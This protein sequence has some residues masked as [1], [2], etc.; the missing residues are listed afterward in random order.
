[1]I[2]VHVAHKDIKGNIQSVKEHSETTA[3]LASEYS[4]MKFKGLVY[5][6]ALFHDI[7][8]YQA[9]FQKRIAGNKNIKIPHALCGAIELNHVMKRSVER[10]IMQY[11]IA[12]HHTGLHNFGTKADT[13]GQGTL[14]GTLQLETEDYSEYKKEIS[15]TD[16]EDISL[17]FSEKCKTPQE[18]GECF[19]FVTRYVYS[20][21]TDADSI[22]TETFCNGYERNRRNSDFQRCL[23]KINDRLNSFVVET[24]LQKA[25]SK[26]QSQ[27]YQKLLHDGQIFFINMP[28][29][30]GKTLCSMKFA[31]E[32]AIQFKKK[33]IIYIIPYNSVIDQTATEF[34]RVFGADLNILRHQSSFKYEVEDGVEEDYTEWA[35][36][37]I[38]NWDGDFIITT[39]VQ[40][41]ESV[42]HNKRGKLRKLHNMGD[43]ILIFDEAHLMPMEY[44]APCL[45]AIS[46]I[47][48]ILNSEA[49][50]LTATMPNFRQLL[51]QHGV[52]DQKIVDLTED[53]S[54]FS[55]FKKCKFENLGYVEIEELLLLDTASKLIIVNSRKKAREIYRECTGTKYHLSTY[56]TAEDR[57]KTIED[58][59]M[60]LHGLEEFG[61]GAP[62]EHRVTV[63]ATS[64]IEAG[65]DLDFHMVCRELSG[66]DHIL[67]A[68][69]RCNREGKRLE[70]KTYIFQFQEDFSKILQVEQSITKN[71]IR[72]FADI[73]SIEAIS[74]YY[75][76]VLKYKAA[77]IIKHNLVV[78]QTYPFMI[79]FKEYAEAFHLINDNTISIVVLNES[80]DVD[81]IV[82][83]YTPINIRKY[84]KNMASVKNYEFDQLLHQG[85]IN[86]F[87]TG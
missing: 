73:D 10:M 24:E 42:Y 84:Q 17:F 64:L 82:N 58:I 62:E 65:V 39:A 34:E 80:E 46:H 36:K 51:E 50:F 19:A 59:H 31:L 43:A 26:V 57:Q 61:D 87:G 56:M 8:K 7:G 40:F 72:N 63:V 77:E 9:S 11:C 14:R 53:T 47:T 15:L 3:Q 32:R 18:T 75:E 48:N 4:T 55:K 28:T 35:N 29:G 23:E 2:I 60:S 69:G 27:V 38:E 33:R 85:V 81:K 37:A 52:R 22:D 49:V 41:F 25:R 54:E 74:T 6:T 67:Q 76:R 13:K 12:G 71:I 21:L 20:C 79:N 5:N 45:K 44:L 86:D 1:M 70:G 68:G 66:L 16:I 78:N 83:S 30:S